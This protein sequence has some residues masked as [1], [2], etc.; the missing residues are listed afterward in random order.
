MSNV[1]FELSDGVLILKLHGHIDSNNAP[2]TEEEINAIREKNPAGSA[3]VD[4]EDLNYLSSAGLRVLLRLKR[5]CPTPSWRTSPPRF[6]T[7][8]K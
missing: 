1:S 3:V 4:C 6:T 8:S 5:P 2:R 7:S